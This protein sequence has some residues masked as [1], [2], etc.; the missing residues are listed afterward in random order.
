MARKGKSKSPRKRNTAI[1]IS[2]LAESYLQIA[3]WTD[4]AFG[5]SPYNFIT[6]NEVVGTSKSASSRI[7]FKELI[8]RFNEVHH[9]STKTEGELVWDNV[10][11]NWMSAA[12]KTVGIGV[13]FRLA[14]RVLRKPKR[15]INALAKSVGVSDLVRI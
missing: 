10:Q 8:Y 2:N 12:I 3:T 5:L 4:A 7:T 15:Q 14:N 13:G 11:K 6:S 9:G 1:N